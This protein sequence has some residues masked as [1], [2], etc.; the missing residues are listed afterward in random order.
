MPLLFVKHSDD[1]HIVHVCY[2][3]VYVFIYSTVYVEYFIKVKT[4]S[5]GL[6]G[7]FESHSVNKCYVLS[8]RIKSKDVLL[9]ELIEIHLTISTPRAWG[10]RWSSFYIWH[11]SFSR[12]VMLA[13]FFNCILSFTENQ[14]VCLLNLTAPSG[15]PVFQM[16]ELI[17]GG[18]MA[19]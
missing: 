13:F 19:C 6:I 7:V 18:L 15:V 9:N 10:L 1:R 3:L 14:F 4:I 16:M 17:L 12:L 8:C 11:W 5:F 2:S